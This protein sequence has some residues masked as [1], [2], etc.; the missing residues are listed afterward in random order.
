MVPTTSKKKPFPPNAHTFS[1][2][3]Q[4]YKHVKSYFNTTLYCLG[5][6]ACISATAAAKDVAKGYYLS[7]KGDSLSGQFYI[8]SLKDNVLKFKAA[9]ADNWTKLTPAD[10]R[11]IHG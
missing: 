8:G 7:N 4:N 6:I 1:S 11:E 2:K 5:L 3:F 9:G 10:I